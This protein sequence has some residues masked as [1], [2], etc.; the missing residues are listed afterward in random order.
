MNKQANVY[1]LLIIG[2][3]PA[4]LTASIYASR[5]RLNHL[6]LGSQLGGA[7]S[8]AAEVENYPGFKKISGLDLVKKMSDHVIS[9]GAKV[10]NQ[11]I[12][13]LTKDNGFF[14]LETANKQNFLGKTIIM[15]SGTQRRKL[16]VSGEKEY[17]GKGVSYC[18]TCDG[19]FFKGKKVVIIGGSNAA[20]M[21]AAHLA[22]FADQVY[23]IY[24]KDPLRAD[25]IWRQ[26][27]ENDPKIKII[28]QTNVVEIIGDGS[29]VT[30]VKL[31]RDYQDQEQLAIDGV[32]IEIGGVPGTALASS[33]GVKLDEKGFIHVEADMS[34]NIEGVWAAGDV[35]NASGEFQQIITAAAE[36]A[37]ASNSVYKY[38]SKMK[39][40]AI[41]ENQH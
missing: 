23:L 6:V 38:L 4:G 11:E 7:A 9:L 34:T 37:L 19:T 16:N 41:N 2:S 21:G 40:G 10:E 36:G 3:G 27:V 1:D 12:T 32:F 39:G 35:A 17:L 22:E 29:K 25:P 18:T 26:R 20:A 31:D 14:H 24:R 30:G 15:A 33:I 28:Y 5:Y 13:K 8:W